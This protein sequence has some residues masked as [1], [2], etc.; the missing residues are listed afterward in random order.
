[1]ASIVMLIIQTALQIL[2][3]QL[4]G[5][6]VLQN[7]DALLEIIAKCRFAYEQETGQPVDESKIKPYIPI[8]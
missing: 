2:N 7:A 3:Q 1:M 4:G 6:P 8:D 5:K